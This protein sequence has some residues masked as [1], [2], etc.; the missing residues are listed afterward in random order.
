MCAFRVLASLASPFK[1]RRDKACTG[2]QR[3]SAAC[4]SDLP[5]HPA[6]PVPYPLKWRQH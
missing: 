2:C 4:P 1:I 6:H 5:A 3:C